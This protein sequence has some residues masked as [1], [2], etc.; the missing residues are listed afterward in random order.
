MKINKKSTYIIA[1]IG[2]NHN[3][4]FKKIINL[5]DLAKNANADAVKFQLY[6]PSSLANPLDKIKKNYF[7][8]K[9]KETLYEMWKRLRIKDSWIKKISEYAID[10][11]IDLGFSIFDIES[12]NKLKNIN[13][14]F[15]KIASGDINN[16]YLIKKFL[17]KKKII[18]L[19]TGMANYNEIKKTFKILRKN[20]IYLLHCV[21]LYPTLTDEV[22]LGRMINLRKLTKN[23][24]FSDHTLG[25]LA[26]IKAISLGAK[27]LEKHF[28][29]NKNADG[30]D[31]KSSANF[32]ELKLI[33]DFSKNSIKY[34]G[35]GLIG[36]GKKEKKMKKFARKSLFAKQKISIGEKFTKSNIEVR[37]P[38]IGISADNFENY[39]NKYSKRKYS[40]GDII[41]I[42]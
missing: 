27:V 19:S 8:F 15:I 12:L 36:P 18:I 30:P 7:S 21:S 33:C 42:T 35:N 5:M 16:H 25:P 13:Y 28:T 10:I 29:Y 6:N 23:I 32:E 9:K 14:K 4:D 26:S 41:K 2:I 24:G 37:R 3:G 20:Q 1:E 38:G 39:L 31:H 40:K 11:K 34:L 17:N 22:N